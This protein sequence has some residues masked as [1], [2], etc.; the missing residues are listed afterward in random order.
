MLT[1]QTPKSHDMKRL[2]FICKGK[3]LGNIKLLLLAAEYVKRGIGAVAEI[4][5]EFSR[6]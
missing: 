5:T 4:E 3:D 6:N 1:H 2:L